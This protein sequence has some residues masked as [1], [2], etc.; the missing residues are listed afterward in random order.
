MGIKR[1][2]VEHFLL[3]K[4]YLAG[5]SVTS[6][7]LGVAAVMPSSLPGLLPGHHSIVSSWE[8]WKPLL[9]RKAMVSLWLFYLVL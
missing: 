5:M 4:A 8:S 1:W 3:T 6:E 2:A 7:P 9:P